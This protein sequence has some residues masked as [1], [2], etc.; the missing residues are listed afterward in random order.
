MSTIQDQ[1]A[2][3][4]T[5]DGQETA[6][7]TKVVLT[8]LSL[9]DNA[10]PLVNGYLEAYARKDEGLASSHSFVSLS[11][12][13]K[14]PPDRLIAELEAQDADVY[15]FSCY[16]WNMGTIRLLAQ[17]LAR[18]KPSARIMLGGHQVANQATQYLLPEQ[19]N[20][21]VCNGEGER[22]FSDF[23]RAG[24]DG[25]AAM[26]DVRG[27]SFYEDG[28]LVT[29][30]PQDKLRDLNEIPSPFL[31][32]VFEK[33]PYGTAVFETNRGC[34]FECT[35]CTWGGPGKTVAR[36]DLD[37]LYEEIEWLS[38]AGVMYL[39]LADANWGML[40]RDIELSRFLGE[41]YQ[42][43]SK[44]WVVAFSAA[45]NQTKG[46]MACV[47]ALSDAGV[48]TTQA[49]G[50]QSMSD[51]VLESIKRSNIPAA[52][53]LQMFDDLEKKGIGSFGELMFPLP[54]QT[55]DTLRQ[56]IAQLCEVRAGCVIL[57]PSLLTNNAEMAET[58]DEWGCVTVP[59]PHE[60]D[61]IE[62]VVGSNT[63]DANDYANAMWFYF[64]GVHPLYNARTLHCTTRALVARGETTFDEMFHEFAQYFRAIEEHPCV[65][66]CRD[67]LANNRQHDMGPIG[68][69]AHFYL[70]SLRTE[71]IQTLC[72]FVTK[73]SWWSD[74]DLRL[75]F[76]VD[77]LNI[78]HLYSNTP[79]TPPERTWE[80]ITPKDVGQ[81]VLTA[82]V[83]DD[84]VLA[85]LDDLVLATKRD[86]RGQKRI[87]IDYEAPNQMPHSKYWPQ[88]H[89]AGYCHG[90]IQR[91]NVILPT[92]RDEPPTATQDS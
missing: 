50:I 85:K 63:V 7:S 54:S 12:R 30:P 18:E 68:M 17:H 38:S 5:S 83:A 29:T 15:G 59:S 37:R 48:V 41:M 40:K 33:K 70:H 27:I 52:Q 60:E 53:Y 4:H 39:H 77:L 91:V 46:A 64:G 25:P 26:H 75:S 35:F 43:N 86:L 36:F 81:R 88:H 3:A 71:F 24:Q 42:K 47:E 76:E 69:F 78:P 1:P 79:V 49:L 22:T 10:M 2:S 72:D 11:R 23:L 84:G 89:V 55:Y 65:V 9:Y 6:R 8:E 58:R 13:A 61:E 21:Y 28:K 31:T 74:P 32:G 34:P 80:F 73:Q 66:T 57:Y 14:T 62:V 90:M 44:P 67:M 87:Q 19:D 45:K 92:W 82:E 20:M 51:T 16:V 56:S